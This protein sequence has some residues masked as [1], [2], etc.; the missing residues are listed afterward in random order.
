MMKKNRDDEPVFDCGVKSQTQTH[1]SFF[2]W[3][4]T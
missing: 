4:Q 2:V 1:F 3:I